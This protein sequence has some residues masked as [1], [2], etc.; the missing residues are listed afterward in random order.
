MSTVQ[1]REA[2]D[3]FCSVQFKLSNATDE[4]IRNK[5]KLKKCCL[6]GATVWLA[7]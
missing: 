7:S 2:S 6:K 3:A 1:T 4:G 5:K